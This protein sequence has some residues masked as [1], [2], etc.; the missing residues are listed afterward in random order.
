L[1]S[2]ALPTFTYGVSTSQLSNLQIAYSIGKITRANDGMSFEKTLASIMLRESSAV[3]GK[4]GDDRNRDGSKRTKV[5]SSLGD[6]QVR[7]LTTREVAKKVKSLY[8]VNTMS[9]EGIANLLLENTQFNLLVSAHY[10]RLYYNVALKK[11]LSKPL[12][13]A[14][15][16]YNGGW[17]NIDYYEKVMKNMKTINNLIKEGKLK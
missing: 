13:R 14:I 15:S 4:I 7:V 9:D 11:G 6:M 2:L 10:V 3:S 17:N 12:Y 5:N 1:V 16:R 8:W